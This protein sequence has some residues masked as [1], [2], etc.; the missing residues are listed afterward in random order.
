[1][2]LPGYDWLGAILTPE[3]I[4]AVKKLET[5]AKDLGATTAQLA[6]AWCAA[7]PRVSTVIMGA[8]RPEQ[9]KENMKALET[10]PKLTPEVMARIEEAVKGVTDL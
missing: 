3:R 10:L 8:S 9:V 4:T 1:V 5:H 7:N 6:L 2:D